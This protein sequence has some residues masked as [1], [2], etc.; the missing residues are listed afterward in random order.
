MRLKHKLKAFNRNAIGNIGEAYEKAKDS[1][2]EAQ[3]QCQANRNDNHLLCLEVEAAKQFH[4]QEKMKEE[5]RIVSFVTKQGDLNNHFPDVVHHF[6]SHFQSIMGKAKPTSMEIQPDCIALGPKLN[7][8]QQVH[9]LKPFSLKEVRAAMFSIPITKSPGPDGYGSGFFRLIWPEMGKD[10]HAAIAHFF[11]TNQ[12]PTELHSTTLSLIPKTESPSKVID[13]RTIACCTTLYKCVSKLIYTRLANVLPNLVS[14]NQGAFVKV[15][16]CKGN[17]GSLNAIQVLLDEFSKTSGLSKNF[18][19]SQVYFGGVAHP[20]PLSQKINLSIGEFPL[21]YL[22]IPL[23]PTKWKLEDYG[24]ILKKMK[25]KLHSWANKQLSYAGRVQLIHST[26][27]GLRYYWMRVFL[28]PQSVIKEIEKLCRGFLWGLKD[29]RSRV[30]LI[31]WERV[32]LPKAYGGLGFKDGTKWNKASL[33]RFIWDLMNKKDLLWVK[34]INSNYLKGSDF[35]SYRMSMDT[36]WYWRKLCRLRT[37][38]NKAD[39]VAVGGEKFK[40]SRFYCSSLKQTLFP[41]AWAIWY[42]LN[43]PK[44]AFQLWQAT[45]D[46]LLTRDHLSKLNIPMSNLIVW[47]VILKRRVIA[48]YSSSPGFLCW[49]C[50]EYFNGWARLVG[51]RTMT[52]GKFGLASLGRLW[53][54]G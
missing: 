28:L 21:K 1:Y 13:Y 34:W 52:V 4:T 23:R 33:A 3:F 41:A 37:T 50:T 25:N 26:L 17:E 5:N 19:K 29:N 9:L 42:G 6:L 31:S 24:P 7:L 40:T 39:I 8:D 36:S 47:F 27:I 43:M 48:T 10:I 32:C 44:H 14:Q 49:F 35:W 38:F 15:T 22:G 46:K 11:E 2:I 53:W 18:A 20:I 51:P 16:F 30:H 45:Q 12:F 54:T